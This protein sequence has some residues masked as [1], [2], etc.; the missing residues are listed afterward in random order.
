MAARAGNSPPARANSGV[1]GGGGGGIVLFFVTAGHVSSMHKHVDI[2][3][4][5]L[6]AY[7]HT[8]IRHS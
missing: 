2:H 4:H 7:V 5:S 1:W 6:N 8:Y 3:T